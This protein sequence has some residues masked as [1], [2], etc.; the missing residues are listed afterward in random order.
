MPRTR[1]AIVINDI[2][3]RFYLDRE[4]IFRLT[5]NFPKDRKFHPWRWICHACP[6]GASGSETEKMD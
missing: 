2:R 6:R 3:K 4:T 1:R 5:H